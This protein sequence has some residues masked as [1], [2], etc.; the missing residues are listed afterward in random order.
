MLVFSQNG[1]LCIIVQYSPKFKRLLG[2]SSPRI[3]SDADSSGVALKEGFDSFFLH[4]I[5]FYRV[6][7]YASSA[8]NLQRIGLVE[9]KL[10]EETNHELRT[11]NFSLHS[12]R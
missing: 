2:Y 3:C 11:S 1:L 10:R 8:W 5:V 7:S 12:F 4:A 9:K 6:V